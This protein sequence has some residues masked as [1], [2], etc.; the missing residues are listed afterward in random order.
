MAFTVPDLPYD[1]DALEPYIDKATM[2]FHQK[3]AGVGGQD[4]GV[5]WRDFA[6]NLDTFMKGD[7]G[8]GRHYF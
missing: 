2:Q 6:K 3:P 5:G 4:F 1:Y 8:C 7:C